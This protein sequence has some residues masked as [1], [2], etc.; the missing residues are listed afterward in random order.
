MRTS[1]N[2]IIIAGYMWSKGKGLGIV[3]N[4]STLHSAMRLQL[5][6]GSYVMHHIMQ[7]KFQEQL[8]IGKVRN[9]I[10][11]VYLTKGGQGL[12]KEDSP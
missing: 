6:T 5:P 12:E 2:V 9:D 8:E 1:P 10:E 7:C 4:N 11:V 3:V